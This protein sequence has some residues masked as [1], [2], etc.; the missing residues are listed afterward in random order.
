MD[1]AGPT[2]HPVAFENI[3]DSRTVPEGS[4]MLLKDDAIHL[5]AF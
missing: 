4:S 3:G 5:H 2:G 1:G